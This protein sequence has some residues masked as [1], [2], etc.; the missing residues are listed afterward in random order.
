MTPVN[1]NMRSFATTSRGRRVRTLLAK[2]DITAEQMMAEVYAMVIDDLPALVPEG[3]YLTQD[4]CGAV[5]WT[6]FRTNGVKRCAGMCLAY[7]VEIRVV[8]IE[9]S[10]APR[11]YPLKFRLR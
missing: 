2:H 6:R 7:L 11:V 8:P 5:L 3:R 4:L 1:F 10:T 9:K